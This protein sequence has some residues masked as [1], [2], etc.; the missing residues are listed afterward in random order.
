MSIPVRRDGTASERR[1]TGRHRGQALIIVAI[2]VV[3]LFASV[4]LA[5]DA[6]VAYFYSVEASRAAAAGALSGVVFMPDQFDPPS[7]QP[8][9]SGNDA[10]DRARAEA[11]RNGYVHGQNGVQ[12]TAA[13][14]P[15]YSNRLSVTVSKTAPSFV[16]RLFNF[17]SYTVSRTAIASYLPPIALGQPGDQLG[18]TVSQLGTT[19]FYADVIESWSVDRENGDPFTP[20]PAF[21]YSTTNGCFRPCTPLSPPATDL[22]AFSGLSGT[23][24]VDPTLP[25]RGGYNYRVTLPAGG[26]IQV[27]NAVFGPDG[28]GG[29]P[30]NYCDN[31]RP[32]V[33]NPLGGN[34]RYR[35]GNFVDFTDPTTFSATE[36]TIFR[37]NNLFI[38]SL[39]QKLSQMTVFP[40]DAS[41]W[42]QPANQYLNVNTGLPITQAYNPVTGRPTNM[43]IYHSWIDVARYPGAGDGGLVQYTPGYGPL[44]SALPAGTYRLRVDSLDYDG[45]ISTSTRP[46]APQAAKMYAVRVRDA[47]GNPC[48][49]CTVSAWNELAIYTPIDGASFSMPLFQLPADYAGLTIN[50]DIFDP[51]DIRGVGDVT[52][53]ILDPSGAVASVA[54]PQTIDIYDLG[55]QRSNPPGPGNLISAPGNTLA[56]FVATS[57]GTLFYNGH[58]VHIELPIPA[59]YSPGPSAWWKLRYQTTVGATATDVITVS[60][61]IKGTPARLTQS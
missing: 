31:V 61:T 43:A 32:A 21:E 13:R 41:N 27:Y 18:S 22:H 54:A 38:R 52:M 24:T 20:N 30:P 10:V 51:G 28:G 11:G 3:L 6:T 14:V 44:I 36:Y 56:S 17:G 59:T 9:A 25:A 37:V 53:S 60:V 47:A 8:P 46:S 23:D 2:M 33:C 50:V 5:I 45:Q 16:M 57:A 4:G 35:E 42:N 39:D 7:A 26:S 34:Y 49:P 55:V 48:G 58:W 29:A 40:I 19:E 15:G 1:S 12:V